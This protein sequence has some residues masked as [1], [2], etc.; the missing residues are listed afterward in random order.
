M[1][2]NKCQCCQEK[3]NKS[4]ERIITTPNFTFKLCSMCSMGME[5]YLDSQCTQEKESKRKEEK[6]TLCIKCNGRVYKNK[7]HICNVK[8]PVCNSKNTL[9]SDLGLKCLKCNYEN[10]QRWIK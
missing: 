3:I 4:E 10:K 8:C 6:Y 7:D 1:V 9:F 5:F 2:R